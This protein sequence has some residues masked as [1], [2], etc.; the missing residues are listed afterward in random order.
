MLLFSHLNM[1]NASKWRW[2]N[3][4]VLE[5][6]TK[7][8]FFKC[9]TVFQEWESP[10]LR[11]AAHL[12]PL[13][14]GLPFTEILFFIIEVSCLSSSGCRGCSASFTVFVTGWSSPRKLRVGVWRCR[15]GT[16]RMELECT[17]CSY[18][19]LLW[20]LLGFSGSLQ[21]PGPCEFK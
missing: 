13:L 5:V 18:T 16:Y 10:G 12:F 14:F 1:T 3:T 17:P 9:E 2:G 20:F 15:E 11:S 7:I 6:W 4:E 8:F 19:T 21:I